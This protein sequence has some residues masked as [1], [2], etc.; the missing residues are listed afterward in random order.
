MR[1]S[2]LFVDI[3][4]KLEELHT[5]QNAVDMALASL[6]GGESYGGFYLCNYQDIIVGLLTQ[7]FNDE[8]DHWLEYFIY[9][10]DW[11]HELKA[12][13]ITYE[14]GTCAHIDSWSDAYHFIISDAVNNTRL[15]MAEED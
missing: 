7:E 12:S 10:K 4:Y 1:L 15:V 13:D 9:E 8:K 14:D 11:L 2:P 6:C 3:M 5:K